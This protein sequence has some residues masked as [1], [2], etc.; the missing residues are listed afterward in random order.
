MINNIDFNENPFMS[1]D[2]TQLSNALRFLAID[3]VQKA[4]SGHPGAPMGMADIATVL[5]RDFLHHNPEN[6]K[7]FNR[8]RFVLSNGHASMLLYALLHLTG[9]DLTIEDLKQFRQLHAKTPGHPEYGETPGVET[10]T[11]PLAQGLANAVGMAIAESILAAHFNQPDFPIVDHYTYV[12]MGDGCL[13][14]GLSHEACSLAGTLQLGKLIAFWDDNKISIDGSVAGWFT[15]NTPERFRAYGWHVIHPVDGHDF[16]AIQ[17]AIVAAKADSSRPTLICCQTQIGAGSPNMA[18]SEKV[19]GAPLGKEEIQAT[20]VALNWP[21]PP[22]EI[23]AALY[24]H[25]DA[26]VKGAALE[27]T[28]RDL[29]EAYQTTHPDLASEFIRRQIGLLPDDFALQANHFIAQTDRAAENIASRK[30]S[31]QAIEVYAALLPELLGGSADLTH[32]NLTNWSHSKP[33]TAHDKTGNYLCY[34]VREFGMSAIMNGIAVHGGFIPFGGTFLTFCDYARSAIRMAALM[35]QRVLFV[36]THDSIG[37]GEDGP[38]HQPVEHLAMLR[39]TPGLSVWRPAD[40]TET[41]VAWKLAIERHAAPTCL[42][43]SRQNLKSQQRSAAQVADIARGAYILLDHPEATCLLIATGSEVG[44]A[45]KAAEA[46]AE[47]N[48]LCRVIS[49]P[50]TDVFDTQPEHYRAHI[51]PPEITNRIAIEAAASDYWYKYVGLSGK[52]IGLNRYGVSA[53]AEAAYAALGITVE[54][55][56]RAAHA[57]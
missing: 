15:D 47:Q 12:F 2:P 20:R 45:M 11:G 33:I 3:A 10:T 51:L 24:E 44:L 55:I 43:F 4:N 28:W 35:H 7:W 27:N 13:M 50:S 30:A 19:H 9:Y 42:V 6:P 39:L 31:Q 21:Y 25:W 41:A 22:F 23:P 5:W 54:H 48:I 32:S 52:I 36:Y 49:M 38:T 56:M 18:N 17:K 1:I 46:L 16:V 8:D 29:F 14:E 40:A 37:L 57:L 34:G 53:P 26:K